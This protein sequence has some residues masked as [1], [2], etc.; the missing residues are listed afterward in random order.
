MTWK[1]R[2]TRYLYESR[3]FKLRQDELVLP[4]GEEITFAT[5]EHPGYA[6]I[7]PILADGRVVM[8]RVYR[9]SLGATLLECPAGG[10]DGE[11]PA[12]AARRELEEETG[13]LADKFEPLGSYYGSSGMSNEQFHL[14]LAHDVTA[15]GTISLESTEEIEVELIPLAELVDMALRAQLTDGPSALAILLTHARLKPDA[16]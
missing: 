6:M 12:V 8:E 7:V 9:H 2:S 4:T 16:T 13:Y 14:F 1:L 3:W 10:L 11:S 5:V 15:D